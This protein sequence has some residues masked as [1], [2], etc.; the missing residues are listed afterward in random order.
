MNSIGSTERGFVPSWLLMAALFGLLGVG[1]G[2]F[3]AHALQ[4]SLE[5]KA[6]GWVE[7]ASD[8]WLAHA[9]LLLGLSLLL[10]RRPSRAFLLSAWSVALGGMLFS[11]SLVVMALSG[12]TALAWITPLGGVLLLLGWGCL[13][14]GAVRV[15]H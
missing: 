10:A 9:P 14:A 11:G 2:A 5:P 7:T 8:Y 6:L 4:G 15:R 1:F 13:A 12:V 3:A